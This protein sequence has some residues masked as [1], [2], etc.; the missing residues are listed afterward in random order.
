MQGNVTRLYFLDSMR[1]SL[2][3]LGIVLHSA[4]VFNPEKSWLIFSDSSSTV[5][6]F[7]ISCISTFRMPAFFVVSGY[8]CYLTLKKYKVKTFLSVRVK[9]LVVPLFFTALT[10]N[11]LQKVLLDRLGNTSFELSSYLS[12]GEY[13]SH[14]WFLINLIIYFLIFAL[15]VLLMTPIVNVCLSITRN[16]VIK[17]PMLLIVLIM[18]FMTISILA[19]SKMGFP[20]YTSLFG[21]FQTSSILLYFP[22]FVFGSVLASHNDFIHRFCTIN[23]ILFVFFFIVAIVGRD[24]IFDVEGLL[25]IFLNEYINSLIK[26]LS[27]LTCF[28]VF[29]RFHS[30]E[31]KVMAILS[32]SAYSVYLFHHFFVILIASVLISINAPA[33]L[34]FVLLVISVAA[35]TLIIHNYIISKNNTLLFMFNGK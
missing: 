20:L 7:I 26:W 15:A 16:F 28:Y 4:Q 23:P 24:L 19:T 5:M 27:V 29:Y 3:M 33:I 11:S 21:V 22:F 9:R 6:P 14:L 35:I 25:F 17:T 34:G 32:D 13:I 18:P 1:A 31:S 12:N 30:R 8:F 10:M 2:M